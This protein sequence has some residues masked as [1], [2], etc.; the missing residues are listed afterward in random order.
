MGDV[1]ERFMR[2]ELDEFVRTR[3][4]NEAR[5][6]T[7]GEALLT[8]NIFDV[9]LDFD[10][11]SATIVDVLEPDV[12]ESVPLEDFVARLDSAGVE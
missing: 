7:T 1:L 6:R 9:R 11:R 10:V 4:L 3:V 2:D 8:F 12:D 5:S